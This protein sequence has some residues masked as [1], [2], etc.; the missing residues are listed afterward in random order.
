MS[1]NTLL[2]RLPRVLLRTGECLVPRDLSWRR[3]E[4]LRARGW[5]STNPFHQRWLGKLTL[6]QAGRAALL[7]GSSSPSPTP[8]GR[9]GSNA[10]A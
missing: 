9:S 1:A 10:E 4:I 5:A 7:A 3:A 2:F 8:A 6:T